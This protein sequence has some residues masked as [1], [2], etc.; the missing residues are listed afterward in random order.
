MN[1]VIALF[2]LISVLLSLIGCDPGSFHYTYEDLEF[3]AGAWKRT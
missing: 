3:K 2:I 1:K